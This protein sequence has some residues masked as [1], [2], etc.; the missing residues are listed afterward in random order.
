VLQWVEM[1]CAVQLTASALTGHWGE[2]AW[3]AA[4][5]LLKSGAVHILATDAHD[6]KRRV[7]ILSDG[8]DAAAE[9]V[10]KEVARILVEDNPRAVVM[11]QVLPY[12]PVPAEKR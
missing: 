3:R 7:P 11:G 5:W 9:H 10:G 8:R 1:G 4:V 6:T 2:A 12:F